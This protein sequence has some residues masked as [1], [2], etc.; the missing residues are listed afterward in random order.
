MGNV[1]IRYYVTHQH[2]GRPKYGFWSPCLKR[3]GKPT[4]M[5]ELG[6]K[7]VSLGED[8]PAAWKLAEEWNKKWDAV[9][10]GEAAIEAPAYPPNS[11]GEGFAKFKTTS[12]WLEQKKKR[13]R[14]DWERGWKLIA[15]VFGDFD[16][17]EVDLGMVDD[18]YA[19][20]LETSGVREAH[21]AMKIW[22]ALW[23]VVGTI[24]NAEGVRYCDREADPSLGIRR[25]TPTPR[26]AVWF[27]GEVVRL[28]KRAWRMKFFGLAAALATMWDTMLSPIDVV[29][30]TAGQREKPRAGDRRKGAR[31]Q[32]IQRTKTGRA[33]LGTIGA[34]AEW[35]LDA[36]IAGLGFDLHDDTQL[37]R[38]RGG[39]VGPKGGRPRPPVAYTVDRLGKDFAIVRAAEFPGDDRQLLD[40]RR[41]GA[42]EADAGD[43]AP[44]ALGAKMSNTI[45]TN[46]ELQRTYLPRSGPQTAALVQ[47]ADEARARGRGKLRGTE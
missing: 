11:L 26:S 47:L 44:K 35:V 45:D 15:P 13:T 25:K 17:R 20:V 39:A 27:E 4:R 9:R 42:I 24:N 36:Y 3:N 21:R 12:A 19:T 37:F 38:T 34:R 10:N 43:V 8:G 2:P 16:P 14:E 23:R 1:K 28:V 18:W 6:F 46:P 7:C 33:V 22:R 5:A 29:K 31:F 30:L 41:S 40:F 32:F